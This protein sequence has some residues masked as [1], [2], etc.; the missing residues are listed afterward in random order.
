MKFLTCYH[1]KGDGFLSRIVAGDKAWVLHITPESNGRKRRR[2]FA[3]KQN[4]GFAHHARIESTEHGMET[5]ALP[6]KGEG[7]TDSVPAENNGY[8]IS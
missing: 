3:V 4:M 8:H 7:Q 5:S 1:E 6:C 2:L